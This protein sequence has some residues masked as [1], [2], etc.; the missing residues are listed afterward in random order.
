MNDAVSGSIK[1]CRANLKWHTF[2]TLRFGSQNES[3][4]LFKKVYFVYFAYTLYLINMWMKLN[5][6]QTEVLRK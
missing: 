2:P 4:P 5:I 1:S 3:S 6:L